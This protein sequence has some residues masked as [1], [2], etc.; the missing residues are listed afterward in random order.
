MDESGSPLGVP[1]L[2]GVDGFRVIF[3]ILLFPFISWT[4]CRGISEQEESQ[5]HVRSNTDRDQW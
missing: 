1:L 2:G 5:C 3:I 4:L